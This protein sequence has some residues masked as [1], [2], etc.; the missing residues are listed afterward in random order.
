MAYREHSQ[1]V[2]S[3]KAQPNCRL[4]SGSTDGVVKVH[5]PVLT[6]YLPVLAGL[7]P[8][9]LIELRYQIQKPSNINIKLGENE[10]RDKN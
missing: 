4:V 9:F 5:S 3:C 1:L 2:L 6:T 10:A 7:P 8:R